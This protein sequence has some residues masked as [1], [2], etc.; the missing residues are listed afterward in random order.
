MEFGV[1]EKSDCVR[2]C[3]QKRIVFLNKG[4]DTNSNFSEK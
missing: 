4:I 1:E 3:I 2:E